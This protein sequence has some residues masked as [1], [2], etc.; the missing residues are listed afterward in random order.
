MAVR[1]ARHCA[2]V[3]EHQVHG[4]VVRLARQAL[5]ARTPRAAPS[6]QKG[7]G[8]RA[9]EQAVEVSGAVAQPVAR[10]VD[11]ER[12][13]EREVHVR[14]STRG[15]ARGIGL[16]DVPHAGHQVAV[17]RSRTACSSSR[18]GGAVTRGSTTVLPSATARSR[19]GRVFHSLPIAHGGEHGARA[20]Y[21]GSATRRST[22][23]RRCVRAPPREGVAPGD[24]LAAQAR[25]LG[26]DG[27][28]V[29]PA[30]LDGRVP[31]VRE[32]GYPR[33]FPLR[34]G[35]PA[36]RIVPAIPALR[37]VALVAAALAAGQP[38]RFRASRRPECTSTRWTWTCRRC[39]ACRRAWATRRHDVPALRHAGGHRPRTM[40]NGTRPAGHQGLPGEEH[41]VS[42]NSADLH[43]GLQQAA[44]R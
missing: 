1:F 43:D 10:P 4:D 40:S 24:H 34:E 42:G 28:R 8:P 16:R 33:V 13:H 31:I 19:N 30:I 9:C 39:P 21:W 27:G 11:G 12:G 15:A 14:K 23:A 22:R 5:D 20:R 7:R 18:R 6:T 25:L 37:R 36:M 41:A 17:A 35:C 38:L 44:C 26:G 3:V 29:H 32:F 2:R